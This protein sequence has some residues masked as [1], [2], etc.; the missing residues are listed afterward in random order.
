MQVTLERYGITAQLAC[1]R[2][3]QS[4]PLAGRTALVTGASSGVGRAIAL[5]LAR[6]SVN[7]CVVGRNQEGLFETAAAAEQFSSVLKFQLDLTDDNNIQSLFQHFQE[8]GGLDILVH[9]AGIFHQDLMAQAS[10]DDLDEQYAINVRAP[11]VLSQRFLP[12][13][14]A[15]RGQ[16]VFINSSVGLS[17]RRPE[18]GQ[19]A[20]TKH[21]LKAVA[22]SLREEV[23][24]NG[25]RVLTVYL[26]RTATPMQRALVQEEGSIYRTETLL[27]PIDIASVIV[28]LL[29]LPRTAEVTDVSI[30]PMMKFPPP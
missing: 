27:Q 17:V 26:G 23:N 7:L 11:Y 19:Y 8:A 6:Q 2:K 9:S 3:D 12:L 14:T 30:R 29:S 13:L 10:V 5:A 21:A 18:V 1:D 15:G 22:D 25:V 20:A 16:I 24:Q 4:S 28:N